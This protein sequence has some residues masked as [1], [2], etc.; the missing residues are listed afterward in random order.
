MPPEY[1]DLIITD[2]GAVP[3]VMAYTIIKEHLGWEV[4]E[5]V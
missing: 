1:I 4:G 2:V 5:M 3:P